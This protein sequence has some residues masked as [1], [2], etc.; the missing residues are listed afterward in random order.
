MTDILTF[1]LFVVAIAAISIW[2]P[3]QIDA[4]IIAR[5]TGAKKPL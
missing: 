1:S 4:D 2:H 5:E 3:K